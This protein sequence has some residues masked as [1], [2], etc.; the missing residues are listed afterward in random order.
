MRLLKSKAECDHDGGEGII[1]LGDT[2]LCQ[3]CYIE[4]MM[5][6]ELLLGPRHVG[7]L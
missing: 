7:Y 3:A 1:L 6:R 4:Y 5:K 2:V